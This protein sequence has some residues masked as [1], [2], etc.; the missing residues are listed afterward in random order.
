MRNVCNF[1]QEHLLLL[2]LTPLH[3]IFFTVLFWVFFLSFRS[4][5]ASTDCNT[6]RYGELQYSIRT[7]GKNCLESNPK[8]CRLSLLTNSGGWRERGVLANEYSCAHHV[9]WSPNKLWRSTS[10]FN[11]CPAHN[12]K[13]FL[14][15]KMGN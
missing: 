10:I 11:L 1:R 5:V 8:R 3:Y 2:F 9:T 15:K 12:N 4:I 7:R 6:G 13:P 14:T